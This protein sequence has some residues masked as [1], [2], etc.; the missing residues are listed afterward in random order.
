QG[1]GGLVRPLKDRLRSLCKKRRIRLHEFF[2][3]FDM[4][5]NRKVTKDQFRRALDQA[6]LTVSVLGSHSTSPL[7]THKEV[8]MLC[9]HYEVP[10]EKDTVNYGKL[11]QQVEKVHQDTRAG[12]HK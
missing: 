8:S 10:G 3:S 4:H 9:K 12:L 5:H 1:P 7:L 6:G 2:K 11:C